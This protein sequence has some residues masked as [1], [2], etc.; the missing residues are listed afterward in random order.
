MKYPLWGVILFIIVVVLLVL[1]TIHIRDRMYEEFDGTS[2]PSEEFTSEGFTSEEEDKCQQYS[3]CS[4]CTTA[5]GCAWC[6]DTNKCINNNQSCMTTSDGTK[7]GFAPPHLIFSEG[8]WG[9]EAPPPPRIFTSM[10][11][12]SNPPVSPPPD[13][14][15]RKSVIEDKP[16]PPNVGLEYAI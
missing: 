1:R 4:T 13:F 2:H 9:G 5:S 7:G 14:T 12:E 6:P 3:S 16:K 11:C 15:L 10:H 8:V